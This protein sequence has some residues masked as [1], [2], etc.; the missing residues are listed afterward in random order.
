MKVSPNILLRF[1][2]TV[3]S[4]ITLGDDMLI[5]LSLSL[6]G[7][8]EDSELIEGDLPLMELPFDFF[9]VVDIIDSSSL[10]LL[11]LSRSITFL[12]SLTTCSIFLYSSS[13]FRLL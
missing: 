5:S 11:G 13:R 9:G 8:S 6:D 7:E 2:G 4:F 10:V 3:L 12:L 1:E